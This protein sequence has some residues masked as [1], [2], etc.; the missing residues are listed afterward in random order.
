MCSDIVGKSCSTNLFYIMFFVV[1]TEIVQGPRN[2]TVMFGE[3]ISLSCI[4]VGHPSPN[5]TFWKI[6]DNGMHHLLSA[7]IG[8]NSY[9]TPVKYY[10]N[11]DSVMLSD[12]GSYYC[13]AVNYLVVN[14]KSISSH[15][16][17]KVICK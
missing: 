4:V 3:S 13:T 8:I 12:T 11:I 1:P 2:M 5:V 10:H 16:T 9:P 6:S 14:S 15:A 7:I 17:L